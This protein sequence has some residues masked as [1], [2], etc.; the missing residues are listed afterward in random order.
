MRT[1]MRGSRL[2]TV[3]SLVLG[4]PR[5]GM[6]NP[7]PFSVQNGRD[8]GGLTFT[9]AGR[10]AGPTSWSRFLRVLVEGD[11]A[12]STRKLRIVDPIVLES[13]SGDTALI[14]SAAFSAEKLAP[15]EPLPVEL[16]GS[17]PVVGAYRGELALIQG[18][19]QRVVPIHVTVSAPAQA[20][21]PVE[22]HGGTAI[23]LT[24]DFKGG[25]DSRLPLRL[26][27]NGLESVLVV[28]SLAGASRVD[29]SDSPKYQLAVSAAGATSVS[30]PIAPQTIEQFDLA[31]SG[32]DDAGIYSVEVML[33]GD[34]M[35]HQP[36]VSKMTV[37]RRESCWHAGIAIL[38]GCLLAW[39]IRYQMADGTRRLSI[40]RRTAIL[41]AQVRAFRRGARTE[42]LATAARALELDIEDRQRDV[43]WGGNL[44]EIESAIGRAE[45]RLALL[46]DVALALDEVVHIDA[47]QQ[48][49]AR[50]ALD[51]ALVTVRNDPGDIKRISDA[52][53]AVANLS[54]VALRR[55]QLRARLADLRDQIAAQGRGSPTPELIA[56]LGATTRTLAGA[57]E[58]LRTDALDDLDN[59]IKSARRALLDACI[60]DLASRINGDAPPG[61]EATWAFDIG[62]I[63]I[64]LD[65]AQPDGEWTQKY[66]AFQSA[67]KTFLTA[68]IVGLAANANERAAA[69]DSR[70][71]RLKQLATDLTTA[72]AKDLFSAA[73]LYARYLGEI[74]APDPNVLRRGPVG[75]EDGGVDETAATARTWAPLRLASGEIP[76]VGQPA[77][78]VKLDREISWTHWLVN[79]GVLL[80]AVLTGLKVLWLDD[81]SW[82]GGSAWLVA[83]LWGAG[84]QGTGDAFVGVVGLRARL[85]APASIP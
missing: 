78:V 33:E 55:E 70:A 58:A 4:I 10:V 6:A 38:I 15:G 80:I 21:L 5:A 65:R 44:H 77:G 31:L 71:A 37:Y 12:Q 49:A 64:D 23:A 39:F 76:V 81:L 83:F 51:A 68:V 85:G 72:L 18:T 41:A 74:T 25:V 32:I 54:L 27:N 79:T 53:E 11:A 63:R 30:H 52:R 14:H 47:D 26:K 62:R 22:E 9:V 73:D 66:Q 35:K 17:F 24:E 57:D 60:V 28:A 1:T 48:A 46:E 7:L 50:R 2:V 61:T 45:V 8:A 40:K 16:K 13:D 82:G 19:R 29:K 20:P 3:L 42:T 34:R 67:Q 36:R 56:A 84:V 75:R 69:G 59:L 43:R